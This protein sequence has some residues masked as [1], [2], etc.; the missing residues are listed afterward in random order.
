MLSSGKNIAVNVLFCSE[1]CN[2]S[3]FS[4]GCELCLPCMNGIG[5]KQLHR[6][7]REHMNKGE[8]KRL[9]P[10]HLHFQENI[11]KQMTPANQ[12]MTNWFQAKCRMDENWCS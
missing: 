7:Y 10:N 11:I 4:A 3:C 12:F 5:I 8:M 9:F 6:S 2:K 1:F